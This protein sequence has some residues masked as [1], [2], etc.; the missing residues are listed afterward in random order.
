MCGKESNGCARP[1]CVQF[2][3]ESLD[4]D[5]RSWYYEGDGTKKRKDQ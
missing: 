5:E 3:L 1:D 4:P 2:E